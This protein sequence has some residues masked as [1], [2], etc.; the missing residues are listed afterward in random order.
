[1]NLRTRLLLSHLVV[2]MA[3]LLV[4]FGALW[5]LFNQVQTRQ[6]QRQLGQVALA[7]VRSVPKNL[8]TDEALPRLRERLARFGRDEGVR[9]LLLNAQGNVLEDMNI[10]NAGRTISPT[11]IGRS[12]GV[13][14]RLT[15]TGVLRGNVAIG[16]F[17]DRAQRWLYAAVETQ[18]TVA[19][20]KFAEWFVIAQPVA[21]RITLSLLDDLGEAM[22]QGS[23]VALI[24]SL[25][26]SLLV[27]R[28]IAAPIQ[29]VTEA[30]NAMSAGNYAQRVPLSGPREMR[31][32]AQDFNNMAAQVQ[33]A[34]QAE[35]DFVAN[36]SHE[37]KTPLTSIQ[38]FAQ[39]IA[40]GAVSEPAEVQKAARVIR[41]EAERLRRLTNGL[42]DSAQIQSGQIRMARAPLDLNEIAQACIERSQPRAQA[43]GVSLITRFAALPV[44]QGDGDRVAQV[45]TNLLDNALKHTPSGGKV[46]LETQTGTNGVEVS[47]LDTGSGI[48]PEDL[49]RIFERFYQVDKSRSDGAAGSGLGLAICKQI[50]EAHGGSLSA[51]SA[52]GVGTRVTMRLPI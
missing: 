10:S 18:P 26:A 3:G 46:T 11:L 6:I 19:N 49:L 28:S 33:A 37:L 13:S 47:M 41:E 29:N 34:Q 8:Q 45:I 14:N 36:V 16:E 1:M 50:V 21:G 22:M 5:L 44:V 42:L 2:G 31:D 7:T 15:I 27:A 52:L 48:P 30:A 39:A 43:A 38:G 23:V 9:V 12:L 25:L 35:R 32:L 24:V 20:P 51:Q 17:R 4:L 40:E